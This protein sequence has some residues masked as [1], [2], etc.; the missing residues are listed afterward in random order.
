MNLVAQD[1][2]DDRLPR[3][4]F[5]L[6]GD[7]LLHAEMSNVLR[8]HQESGTVTFT[9]ILP[10][11]LVPQYLDAA[12]VLVSPHV[13]M[14]DGREFFGSPTKLF[15]YMA[16]GKAIVAS[17][18][19]QLGRV[20]EHNVTALLV[21]PGDAEDLTSAIAQL[22]ADAGLR[23]RLGTA[24]RA[25]ALEGHTWRQNAARVLSR[26]PGAIVPENSQG[27]LLQQESHPEAP[28]WSE[29]VHPSPAAPGAKREK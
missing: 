2:S 27:T 3:L 17:N 23:K 25:A 13:P 10:H 28:S 22:T 9:G 19:G 29:S 1:A 8:E 7:G 5:L 6:V 16:M 21:R 15:E 11:E 12:D 14:P 26:L 24:A 20:L 4:K 18:L